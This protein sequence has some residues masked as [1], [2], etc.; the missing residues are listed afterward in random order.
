MSC[1]RI[2]YKSYTAIVALYFMN[3][4]LKDIYHKF[5]IG[6]YKSVT[7]GESSDFNYIMRWIP[8]HNAVRFNFAFYYGSCSDDAIFSYLRTW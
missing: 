1:L 3:E 8:D 7:C 6:N 2:I 5:F 4:I